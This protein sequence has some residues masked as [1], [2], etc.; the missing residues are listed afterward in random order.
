MIALKSS[1]GTLCCLSGCETRA[2]STLVDSLVTPVQ[3]RSAWMHSERHL[4]FFIHASWLQMS[5]SKRA[6]RLT[7]NCTAV[8]YTISKDCAWYP[9]TSL[10]SIAYDESL[11]IST[12]PA[13]RMHI[14][15]FPDS[16]C[17]SRSPHLTVNIADTVERCWLQHSSIQ[18][19]RSHA[20][21]IVGVMVRLYMKI[22]SSGHSSSPIAPCATKKMW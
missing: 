19:I 14:I 9:L 5:S 12:S 20:R 3:M 6:E 16:L 10:R 1:H 22:F 21:V 11:H 7:T 13:D 8:Y 18:R 17:S 2:E 4:V 15:H